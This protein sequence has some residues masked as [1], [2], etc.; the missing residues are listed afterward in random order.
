LQTS[1]LREGGGDIE[2]RR[3][4]GG[5]ASLDGVSRC[6]AQSWACM[7][8]VEDIVEDVQAR[9]DKVAGRGL[10]V[11]SRLGNER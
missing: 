11:R 1:L 8:E 7:Y 9:Q 3:D 2:A 5:V 10:S 4:I 6:G